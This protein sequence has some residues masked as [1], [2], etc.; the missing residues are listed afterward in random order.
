MPSQIPLQPMQLSTNFPSQ[1]ANNF[2]L[3]PLNNFFPYLSN[4]PLQ[5]LPNVPL[6]AMTNIPSQ[7][8]PNISSQPYFTLFSNFSNLH[9]LYT[10]IN[11]SVL[12][13]LSSSK[14]VP[15]L[16]EFLTK[17]DEAKNANGEI[18]ACLSKFQNQAI[19]VEQISKLTDEQLDLVGITKAGWKIALQE[20]S[21]EYSQ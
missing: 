11:N 7:L 6:Y 17:I 10:S 18:L 9:P 20:A 12:Q 8:L 5:I 1:I 3:Q 4:T 13:G 16:D 14:P 15:Q 2:S 21:K 19:Q